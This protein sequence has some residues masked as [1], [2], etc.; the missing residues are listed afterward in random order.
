M[1]HPAPGGGVLRATALFECRLRGSEPRERD[2]VG[3][4]ADVVEPEQVAELDRRRLAPV[5]AADAELEVGLGAAPALD[6][7]AHQVA[8]AITVERLERVALDDAVFEIERQ[9]LPLRVVA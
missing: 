4:A 8:D 9:E 7:D 2:A 1:P 3:R 5:L 6:A